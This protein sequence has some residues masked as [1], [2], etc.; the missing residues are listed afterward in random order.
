MVFS[1]SSSTL[2]SP[3]PRAP[4]QSSSC[5][6]GTMRQ[7]RPTTAPRLSWRDRSVAVAPEL[8]DPCGG[9]DERQSCLTRRC[10]SLHI[11]CLEGGIHREITGSGKTDQ[12]GHAA[13][14]VELP[15][16]GDHRFPVSIWHS[17]PHCIIELA[18]G[19]I[20]G[21]LHA[22]MIRL[23]KHNRNARQESSRRSRTS[24]AGR[25]KHCRR[26][27]SENFRAI[28][29]LPGAVEVGR[30][31]DPVALAR[32]VELRAMPQANSVR[33]NEPSGDSSRWSVIST[34]RSNGRTRSRCAATR[35]RA[36]CGRSASRRPAP[37]IRRAATGS[38]CRRRRTVQQLVE[39]V[40]AAGKPVV[41][42]SLAG[43]TGET[44]HAAVV[45]H[46]LA[47]RDRLA[48]RRCSVASS[49]TRALSRW[50]L[51]SVKKKWSQWRDGPEL[52]QAR[53]PDDPPSARF[54]EQAFWASKTCRR[55]TGWADEKLR[56]G[57]FAAAYPSK[58]STSK[59][60]RAPAG[61][62]APPR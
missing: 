20:D 2:R 55:V 7:H 26:D 47:Q 48:H 16:R 23:R 45:E 33:C 14:L 39:P 27:S 5:T 42:G 53:R 58:Y 35:W 22:S 38:S 61:R 29:G 51:Q 24:R 46:E 57:M 1:I 18:L 8:F 19:N 17:E 49:S 59:R 9:V 4:F 60:S 36:P 34:W 40:R 3:V 54:V 56:G 31:E 11:R 15:Q 30:S 50:P 12:T 13:S 21:G 41:E 10:R 44:G 37:D 43:V 62:P 32:Q 52:A 25:R 28:R 6:N